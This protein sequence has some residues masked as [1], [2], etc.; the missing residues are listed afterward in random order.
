MQDMHKL[1]C[2]LIRSTPQQ[3]CIHSSMR[4]PQAGCTCLRQ[5]STCA[6]NRVW[7]ALFARQKC[8]ILWSANLFGYVQEYFFIWLK[9]DSGNARNS[10]QFLLILIQFDTALMCNRSLLNVGPNKIRVLHV[11]EEILL[12]DFRRGNVREFD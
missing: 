9:C 3:E 2:C 11:T 8:P 6:R 12:L 10:S 4:H 5:R 1:F 7:K